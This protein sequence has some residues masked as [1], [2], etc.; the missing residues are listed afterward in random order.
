MKNPTIFNNHKK[1][2]VT[3]SLT[4][5][6]MRRYL[7]L[8]GMF[9]L[10]TMKGF[11]QFQPIDESG[12]QKIYVSTTGSD[13]GTGLVDSPYFSIKKALTEAMNLK[14]TGTGVKVIIAGG[15]Y[16]KGAATDS[17]TYNLSSS[18]AETTN[19]PLVIEGAGW[20]ASNPY[21]T[22]DVI[23]SAS[24]DWSGGWTR[25]ADGTW[26]KDWPYAWG[27]PA[28][29]TGLKRAV[30]DAFVR[31][32][33]VHV[34]GQT[35]YQLN[36]P[37][38]YI[39]VN[40][41]AGEN[42]LPTNAN[43][44]RLTPEEGAFWVTDAAGSAQ[45]KITIK[46]PSSFSPSFDL[47]ASSNLVEVTTKRGLLQIT[48]PATSTVT[49]IVIRNLTFQHA[50]GSYPVLIMRQN[51]LLI[52][53]CRFIKCHNGGLHV[54]SQNVLLRRVEC[55]GNGEWGL[56][57]SHVTNALVSE[58]KL[59]G[60]SR[61]AQIIAY[62][63]WSACASKLGY[64]T[65]VTIYRTESNN[66]SVRGIWWD[67]RNVDCSIVESVSIGN[68]DIGYYMEANNSEGNN[69]EGMGT[70]TV[71]INGILNLG[72]RPTVRVIRCVS[73]HNRPLPAMMP[74]SFKG[75]GLEI[76]ASEN[77]YVEGS[78]IYDSEI[79]VSCHQDKR[80]EIRNV[81]FKNN[82]IASQ[83]SGKPLYSYYN[84]SPD[85]ETIDAVNDN[86]VVVAILKGSWYSLF[87]ALSGSTNYNRYFYP[88]ANAFFSR[89]QRQNNVTPA[90]DLAGWRSAHL[91]NPNN[92]FADKAVDANSVLV[93]SAYDETKPLVGI[94]V[95]TKYVAETDPST[96]VF[97]IT[98]V[99]GVG[100]GAPL[101]VN[102]SVR[103]NAGDATNGT[104]FQSLP[105]TV[106]IPANSRSVDIT[107]TPV[108]DGITENS[109]PL[110]LVLDVAATNYVVAN[111]KDSV[112]LTDSKYTEIVVDGLLLDPDTAT[113][114]NG[115]S[116]QLVATVSPANATDQKLIWNSS[117]PLAATINTQ[118]LVTGTGCGTTVITARS[119]S[120][121][122]VASSAINVI[123]PAVTSIT[124]DHSTLALNTDMQSQ[125]TA[126]VTPAN[127][128]EP[129]IWGSG[130]TGVASVNN[131]GKVT[132]ISPG[133]ATITVSSPDG[134]IKASCTVTVSYSTTLVNLALNRPV[135]VSA[136]V[137][138]YPGS[139]A[140][141]GDKVSN[142]SR[143]YE[144]VAVS[145]T[146]QWIEINLERNCNITGF[147]TWTGALGY[148]NQPINDFQFQYWDGS[149]W[150]TIISETGNTDATYE[151]N[152]TPV[153]ASKVRLYI[154]KVDNVYVRLYEIEVY[155]NSVQPTGINLLKDL[156]KAVVLPFPNP[157]LDEDLTILLKGFDPYKLVDLSISDI[158]G[159]QV[160]ERKVVPAELEGL[161]IR[162]S[163]NVFTNGVYF[164]KAENEAG[165][166][167]VVK[168]IVL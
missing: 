117:N 167:K 31:R 68:T 23:I 92:G 72:V 42:P 105:G 34:N 147:A 100:Y 144:G 90:L 13:S 137:T 46:P 155:G 120:G 25:N 165:I 50:A 159:R 134:T 61:H 35:F 43:G 2:Y 128:C 127:V 55:S 32:E 28:R 122:K 79:Q 158:T 99:S 9:I 139:N 81:M 64:C 86:G 157:I 115:S 110:V 37:T 83:A 146:P 119:Q 145:I 45:G 152:F 135:T 71:G 3:G 150:R 19:A 111:P 161:P 58:C 44:D 142:A 60:N 97:T 69:Y 114:M 160:F 106:V 5:L 102:Y 109:E 124:L 41:F 95:N 136:Y 103:A 29:P 66:N 22:G 17:Y 163:R 138:D 40:T 118:G 38:G 141:D 151:K 15:T 57:L 121:D 51:N 116:Q 56:G 65:N 166:C 123:S 12:L 74:Y 8:F 4:E 59:N 148:Y 125:L 93:N 21:N 39:N 54:N 94:T 62:P 7:F 154:T 143:W 67:Q 80:G 101:T 48:C 70:G 78:L 18:A 24:E 108:N 26:F 104:D 1:K 156:S 84:S 53:D 63:D 73:A 133:T 140:V 33:L 76:A 6:A 112:M 98:R 168:I 10:T 49:N 164:I 16:R 36:P 107:V 113:L 130:N 129:M 88:D 89:A 30:S 96:N 27:V 82:I 75:Q 47:N 85:G 14:K 52:E 126:T 11:S 149:A 87:D 77:V 153:I 132:G 91:N 20:D 162:F 131:S